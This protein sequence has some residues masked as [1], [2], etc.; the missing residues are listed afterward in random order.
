MGWFRKP[1]C[2]LGT[3]GST[4]TL[5]A[6]RARARGDLPGIRSNEQTGEVSEW[7][8]EH[9]WKACVSVPGTVGSNPT[10]SANHSGIGSASLVRHPGEALARSPASSPVGPV[11]CDE[12]GPN[13]V[14]PG[15]EQP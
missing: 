2:P 12:S 6:T 9:A 3:V 1:V 4:P 5:S 14:R 8:K 15:T 10:L 13:R 7:L 11:P